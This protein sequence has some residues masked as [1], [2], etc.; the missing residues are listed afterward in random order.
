MFLKQHDK[1]LN[2]DYRRCC[3]HTGENTTL[4]WAQTVSALRRLPWLYL[5]LTLLIHFA[6]CVWTSVC[7]VCLFYYAFMK[8]FDLSFK[9]SIFESV[10][11]K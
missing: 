4:F 11:R 5:V 8:I 7:T 2:L 3:C 10:R 1:M 9:Q 6:D